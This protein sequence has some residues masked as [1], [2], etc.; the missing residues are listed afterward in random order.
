MAEETQ[1]TE[2]TVQNT[3][4]KAEAPKAAAAKKE[5]LTIDEKMDAAYDEVT[6]KASDDNKGKADDKSGDK[7][8]EGDSDT[9]DQTNKQGSEQKSDTPSLTLFT[10][11]ELILL[12]GVKLNIP[13]QQKLMAIPVEYRKAAIEAVVSAVPEPKLEKKKD[14]AS[15]PSETEAVN[16]LVTEMMGKLQ[17]DNGDMAKKFANSMGL[18]EKDVKEF[19]DG[20]RNSA[21]EPAI[22]QLAEQLVREKAG[23]T[24]DKAIA[25]RN[26]EILSASVEAEKDVS[27]KYG[28]LVKGDAYQ[29]LVNTE[30]TVNLIGGYMMAGLA[31]G[32]A[33]KKAIETRAA[34]VY[35][36]KAALK[37]AEASKKKK[38]ESL[39]GSSDP[40]DSVRTVE[41]AIK[42]N[43]NS[44]DSLDEIMDRAYTAVVEKK[45]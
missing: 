26:Q 40:G 12:G 43:K 6:G 39:K 34:M 35:G 25:T 31:P 3:D 37:E 45:K 4:A 33:T 30:E 15:P 29:K 36:P 44:G 7:G 17:S 20:I 14:E 19:T 22:R 18:D 38:E 5:E 27:T 42:A 28:D 2:E 13:E 8:G 23:I 21:A 9:G 1:K 11:E 10:A 24:E 16:T 32:E 41:A